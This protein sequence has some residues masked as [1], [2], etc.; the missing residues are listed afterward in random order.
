VARSAVASRNLVGARDI[1]A[2]IDARIRQRVYP[3]LPRPP[4]PWA[5]RVPDLAD[6][7][8]QAYV[9]EIAAMMDDHALY[10]L[11]PPLPGTPIPSGGHYRAA[12]VWVIL[13]QLLASG[14]LQHALEQTRLITTG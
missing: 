2:V 13:D 6:P 9:T 12:R 4:G 10:H 5:G 11:G 1:A 8:R 7:D 3:L 14:T